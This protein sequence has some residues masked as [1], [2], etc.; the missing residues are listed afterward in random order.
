MYQDRPW[1]QDFDA[2]PPEKQAEVI[3]FI[4]FLKNKA[5]ESAPQKATRGSYG[6]LKGTF[7]MADDIDAPLENFKEDDL[8]SPDQEQVKV[9]HLISIQDIVDALDVASDETSSYLNRVT[10]QV[11]TLLQEEIDDA[12]NDSLEDLADWHM[13]VI[14]EAKQVLNSDDWLKLPG[15]FAIHEWN[16]MEEFSQGLSSES[17]RSELGHA[18][19]G[20]GAFRNFKDTLRRLGIES[21]WFDYKA[22]AL[23]DIARKWLAEQGLLSENKGFDK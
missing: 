7:H 6:S 17:Q 9:N 18:L 23:E 16:I 2:L 11:I 1:L 14:A 8:K 12:Q 4:G 10:G 21:A 3:D 19:R 22:K 13:E 20:K 15:K 5:Q